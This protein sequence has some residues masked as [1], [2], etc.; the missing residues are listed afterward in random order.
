MSL[1]TW[2]NQ[3]IANKSPTKMSIDLPSQFQIGEEIELVCLGDLSPIE[4]VVFAVKFAGNGTVNYDIA[5]PIKGTEHF[6]IITDIRG[7]M[8]K[9]GS[10]ET[11]DE[12]KLVGIEEITPYLNQASL[13][14]VED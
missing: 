2:F 5:V 9:K 6:T 3:R 14:V 13:Y 8:R 7:Q 12:L 10:L 4:G 11:A 1:T